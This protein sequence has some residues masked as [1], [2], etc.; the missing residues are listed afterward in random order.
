M[1]GRGQLRGIGV[2]VVALSACTT[3]DAAEA[4][5]ARAQDACHDLVTE[6]LPYADAVATESCQNAGGESGCAFIDALKERAI[7]SQCRAA[8]GRLDDAGT[9]DVTLGR[10]CTRGVQNACTTL[11]LAW[12]DD[13]QAKGVHLDAPRACSAS[14]TVFADACSGP[15]PD[16]RTG[17]ETVEA[18]CARQLE[19]QRA[20]QHGSDGSEAWLAMFPASGI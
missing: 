1:F 19:Q 15:A 9:D 12:E 2:C 18:G 10:A 5:R 8:A 14:A 17:L 3:T 6:R 4:Q 13:C 16:A 20:D 7:D 11:A